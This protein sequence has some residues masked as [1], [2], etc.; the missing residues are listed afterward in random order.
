MSCLQVD[1]YMYI[2]FYLHLITSPSD[3]YSFHRPYRALHVSL[4]IS[5]EFISLLETS[6]NGPFPVLGFWE[7]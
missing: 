3:V 5:P 6:K 7:G 4:A 2:L 1:A